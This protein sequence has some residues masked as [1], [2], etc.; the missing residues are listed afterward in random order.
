MKARASI[1]VS[2]FM[3]EKGPKQSNMAYGR[4]DHSFLDWCTRM[5]EKGS[6]AHHI[7]DIRE[8]DELEYGRIP[9]AQNVPESELEAALDLTPKDWEA[10]YGYPKPK[11]GHVVVVYGEPPTG[12]EYCPLVQQ[13][14]MRVCN[15]LASE[16]GY[17]YVQQY[18]VSFYKF[19]I[20]PYILE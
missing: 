6:M 9:Y 5:I 11:Q 14:L 13:R 17:K 2:K 16:Y 10:R 1:D 20:N 19:M 3:K 7:L 12:S 18:A 15:M 8:E 4:V